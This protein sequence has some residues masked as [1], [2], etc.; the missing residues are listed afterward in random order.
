MATKDPFNSVYQGREGTGA[1]FILGG[2]RAA[3]VYRTNLAYDEQMNRVAALQRQR[4][5]QAQNALIDKN[6][7]DIKLE[8]HW[9]AHDEDLR[10][11]YNGML[12]YATQLKAKGVN[13]TTDREFKNMQEKLNSEAKYSGQLLNS[14]NAVQKEIAAKPDEYSEESIKRVLSFYDPKKPISQYLK[15][16]LTP[17][18]LEPKY[19]LGGMLKGLKGSS[20]EY[21]KN[22]RII[23]EA[24]RSK[25]VKIVEG[26]MDRSDFKK[27]VSDA[28]ADPNIGAFPVKTKDGRT[29]Y[30][31]NDEVLLPM[32]DEYLSQIKPAEYQNFGMT[33]TTPE[34]ARVQMLDIIKRQNA[35]YGTVISAAADQLDAG[36]SGQ[37]KKDWSGD[38]SA[39]GWAS[40]KLAR[41]RENRIASKESKEDAKETKGNEYLNELKTGALSGSKEGISRLRAHLNPINAN[42]GYKNGVL[43]IMVPI[44]EKKSGNDL[45]ELIYGTKTQMPKNSG[46]KVTSDGK[47]FRRY[48]IGKNSGLT[49]SI[50]LDNLLKEV[51]LLKDN[52]TP[53]K[54]SGELDLIGEE[55]TFDNL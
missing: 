52:T 53:K 12:N 13:P 24:D 1:A 51:N 37:S 11:K 21:D 22:G 25:N 47:K 9:I 30:S 18:T 40:L 50:Y 3:E 41:E 46:E 32:I 31:T 38:T 23:K 48:K 26:L 15:D 14:L 29:I 20:V 7:S 4:D 44:E 27:F 36:V 34:E 10:N 28:G 2:N 55:E 6:I 45:V 35:A 8:D 49:G 19:T 16:G 5:L 17:P 43:E 33:A 39:R 42:V 54:Y